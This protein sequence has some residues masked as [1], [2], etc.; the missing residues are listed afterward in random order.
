MLKKEIIK[1]SVK[2]KS[3]NAG[4]FASRILRTML[5]DGK[6][7]AVQFVNE[8]EKRDELVVK[9]ATVCRIMKRMVDQNDP[10]K[11]FGTTEVP[12]EFKGKRI[13]VKTS[14]PHQIKRMINHDPNNLMQLVRYD[15]FYELEPIAVEE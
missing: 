15:F 7:V 10:T 5:K 11:L 1:L 13:V 12:E 14:L 4:Q 6:P 9:F 3:A 2:D 8:G